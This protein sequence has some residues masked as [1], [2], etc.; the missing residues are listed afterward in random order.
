MDRE[1]KKKGTKKII[2]TYIADTVITIIDNIYP[3]GLI[4]KTFFSYKSSPIYPHV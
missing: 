1:R 4:H 2:I 3:F